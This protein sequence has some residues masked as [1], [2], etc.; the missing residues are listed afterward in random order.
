[1]ATEPEIRSATN[2]GEVAETAARAGRAFPNESAAFFRRR[3]LSAPALPLENTL[4]LLLDGEIAS[5]LQIYERRV[6]LGERFVPVGAIGNVM[7]LPE[8]RGEGYASRLL[9]T[10]VAF[11]SEKGYALSLLIGDPGFYSRLGWEPLP[12]TRHVVTDP[13]LAPGETEG[14]WLAFDP[15][16]YLDQVAEIRRAETDRVDGALSRPSYLWRGWTL[17]HLVGPDDVRLYEVSGEVWGY[18]VGG[19][20]GDTNVCR[21]IGWN[22][23]STGHTDFVEACWNLLA[24]G[25]ADR[26][27]WDPPLPDFVRGAGRST[28][29]TSLEL[30]TGEAPMV[31]VH[32]AVA[33]VDRV[34]PDSTTTF[35]ERLA[36]TDWSLSDLDKF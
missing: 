15:D 11:M 7:T 32:E 26:I 35:V 24:E 20:D 10:A 27:R 21:E 16:R 29:P 22:G 1:M 13:D 5:S 33:E 36:G 4:L 8:Y 34:V 31:R 2:W 12:D 3:T 30:M 19:E 18:L 17:A 6:L 14:R 9:D 23:P 25:A 28:E